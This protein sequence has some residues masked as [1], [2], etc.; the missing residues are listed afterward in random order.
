LFPAELGYTANSLEGGSNGAESPVVTGNLDLRGS[1]IQTQRGGDI[2]ILGPGGQILVGSSSAP[3]VILD[4]SGKVLVGPSEQ[5]ILAM[6][7]GSVGIFTDRSVLLAQSRVFTQRGGDIVM[8]SSNGDVNAGKGAKTSS[9][10]APIGYDCDQDHYCRVDADGQVT[11]AG[12]AA[13]QTTPDSEPGDAVLV[14]PRG[15]VDAGDA[16]IRVS[17]NLVIAAFSVANADNIQVQGETVGVPASAVNVGALSTASSAAAAAQKSADDL[18]S[19]RP[20]ERAASM[21]SV[22]VVGFGKP[23]E[24]QLKKLQESRQDP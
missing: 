18:A 21:I 10:K 9:E 20:P 8:W 14:A 17:G 12:I 19:R 15:T 3:P 7:R 23:D 4:S 16:G 6:E 24:A 13:L 2:S 11:G 1:T 5:G 22:E